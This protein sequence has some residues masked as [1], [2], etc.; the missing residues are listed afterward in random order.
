MD[1]DYGSMREFIDD[2]SLF[3]PSRKTLTFSLDD[4]VKIAN[5]GR[6]LGRE[7]DE[8]HRYPADSTRLK[9]LFNDMSDERYKPIFSKV[10]QDVYR[11]PGESVNT[12]RV[13]GLIEN[14]MAMF[15]FEVPG[16][17]GKE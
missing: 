7:V 2:M 10:L 9:K 15:R 8:M 4:V 13:R 11:N 16:L 5:I 6:R 1:K 14:Y 3:N 12:E 17:V